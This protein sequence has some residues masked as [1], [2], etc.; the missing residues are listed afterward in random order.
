MGNYLVLFG[1]FVFFILIMRKPNNGTSKNTI[2]TI[3]GS[4][5]FLEILPLAFGI[6][7]TYPE[8]RN[9]KAETLSSKQTDSL[10]QFQLALLLTEKALPVWKRYTYSPEFLHYATFADSQSKIESNLL[11]KSI[12]EIKLISNTKL[13]D[14]ENKNIKELY[15]DFVNPVIAL[16]DGIWITPYPVKKIFLSVYYLL[17]SIV[18]KNNSGDEENF[19]S[20]A[21]S[22]AI[23]C[24]ELSKLY[25][26]DEVTSFLAM[27]KPVHNL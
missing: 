9:S 22:C 20:I 24:L 17:K 3:T 16:Q 27:H 14:S 18:E 13:A 26:S 11:Q 5:D 21:I 12:E 4:G 23:E 2:N 10:Q 8:K 6:N 25:S 15:N 7:N 1:L 19:L